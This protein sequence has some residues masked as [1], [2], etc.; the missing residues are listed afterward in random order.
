MLEIFSLGKWILIISRKIEWRIFKISENKACRVSA[1][2]LKPCA[3][4]DRMD[5]LARSRVLHSISKVWF[6]QRASFV[7]WIFVMPLCKYSLCSLSFHLL[8]SSKSV[9][10]HLSCFVS[11]T[12]SLVPRFFISI[13]KL[14]G[15]ES[16]E[17][18][19]S[20]ES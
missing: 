6:P 2:P 18:E 10:E 9:Q 17:W 5:S 8:N 1:P 13:F 14:W 12:H 7:Q 4:L 15:K 19:W 3:S 11:Y 16:M 20:H